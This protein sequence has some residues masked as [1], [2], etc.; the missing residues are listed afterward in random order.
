MMRDQSLVL[1]HFSR[2]DIHAPVHLHG[3]GADDF[4]VKLEGYVLGKRGF[5]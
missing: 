4:A 2:A 1:E 5:A 3:I